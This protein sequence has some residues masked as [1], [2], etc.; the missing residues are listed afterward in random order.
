MSVGYKWGTWTVLGTENQTITAASSYEAGNI[1]SEGKIATEV[2]VEGT[3]GAGD[4]AANIVVRRLI[5]ASS[6]EQ[7]SSAPWTVPLPATESVT[8]ERTITIPGDVSGCRIQ[9]DNDSAASMT[10]VTVRYRQATLG[11]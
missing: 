1:N 2:S 6:Y 9:V 4:V 8:R 5:G 7:D 3:Y 10:N 11:E